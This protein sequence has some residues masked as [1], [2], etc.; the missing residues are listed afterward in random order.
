MCVGRYDR[1]E[2]RWP[3]MNLGG[4]VCLALGSSCRCNRRIDFRLPLSVRLDIRDN[5]A[6]FAGFGF[7]LDMQ[8]PQNGNATILNSQPT[9]RM[10]H[11]A[12]VE[13]RSHELG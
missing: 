13:S 12:R 9:S 4:F 11:M 1:G 5:G 10:T 7:C 6:F 3:R 2:T 8:G